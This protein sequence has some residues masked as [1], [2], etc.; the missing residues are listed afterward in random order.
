MSTK[1]TVSYIDA[2]EGGSGQTNEMPL[3]LL[4]MWLTARPGVVI[5]E[6]IHTDLQLSTEQ[7]NVARQARHDLSARLSRL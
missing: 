5:R 6:I 1:V 2:I 7:R 4:P 3:E